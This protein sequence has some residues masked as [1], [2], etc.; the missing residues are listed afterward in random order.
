[1]TQQQLIT[2][3]EIEKIARLSHIELQQTEIK[4]TI[5][6]VSAVLSYAARVQEIAKDVTIPSLKTAMLNVKMLLFL[7]MH[8]LFWRKHQNVKATSLLFQ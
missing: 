6:H 3:E 2:H 5:Q 1:M 8:K 4:A 7:A